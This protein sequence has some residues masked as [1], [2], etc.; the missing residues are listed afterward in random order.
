MPA[1][2]HARRSSGL[3]RGVLGSADAVA[4]SLA[5]LA[6]TFAVTAAPALAAMTAGAAVPVAYVIAGSAAC[7]WAR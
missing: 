2:A 6:L 1:G 4:Q 3:R 7:A 5:L